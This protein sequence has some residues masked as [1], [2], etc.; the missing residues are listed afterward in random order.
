LVSLAFA[1]QGTLM[2]LFLGRQSIEARKAEGS[3]DA[4]H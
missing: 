1:L 4:G 3:D 2:V